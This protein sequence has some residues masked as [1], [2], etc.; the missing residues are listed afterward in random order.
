MRY[1]PP[2]GNSDANASYVNGDPSNGVEG[3]I[4]DCG[5]FEATQ[6]EIVAAIKAA[7]LTP[8]GS[9][10]TQL[11]QGLR[12]GLLDYYVDQGSANQV[13]INPSVVFVGLFDGY[14]FRVKLAASLTGPATLQV[15]ANTAVPIVKSGGAALT[16]GE[17]AAGD[18]VTFNMTNG[19]AQLAGGGG[20]SGGSAGLLV[21][22]NTTLTVP[23]QYPTIQAAVA[24]F[25]RMIPIAGV[26]VTIQVVPTSPNAPYIENLG[27]STGPIDLRLPYG[28][29]LQIVA[30]ALNGNFPTQADIVGKT[31][32]QALSLV[33]GRFNCI[34]NAVGV[35][36]I[37]IHSGGL[38]LLSN[39][40]VVCD[41]TA[42]RFAIKVGDWQTDIGVGFLGVQ[43]VVTFGAGQN[44]FD[45]QF[46][47][48]VR[49]TNVASIYN[50]A[51][52]FR[53]AH[54]CNI[55]VNFGSILSMYN[56]GSGGYCANGGQISVDST[57]GTM[58][59][60]YNTKSGLYCAQTGK[61]NL[62]SATGVRLNNN[63]RYAVE[64]YGQSQV[65]L[66][67]TTTY[68]GN[69]IGD[70]YAYLATII[71]AAGSNA[72]TCSPAKNTLSSDA[73]RIVV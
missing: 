61:A 50:I 57:G 26:I 20:S 34:I 13:V 53:S 73:S 27:A 69:G 17:A 1:Y 6:R 68:G 42:G 7:N 21:T 67:S 14:K 8:S 25:S 48:Y 54:G 36:G 32:A 3:S 41:G 52:G 70:L 72:G 46:G 37:Q 9:D 24:A 18:V 55:E 71:T 11:A 12:S 30:P 49:A 35:D 39:V 10:N 15:N 23:S 65:N 16:G 38:N 64:G 28:N 60:A 22:Q 56:G 44:G 33:Q 58:D 62:L 43:N 2:Y 4:P 45:A 47:G 40:L 19:R 66:P 5:G 31:K 51:D 29:Q 59:F 63:G